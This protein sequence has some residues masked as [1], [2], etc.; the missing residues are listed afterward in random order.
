MSISETIAS[1]DVGALFTVIADSIGNVLAPQGGGGS[2]AEG[3][4]STV[5]KIVSGITAA[6][7]G[8]QELVERIIETIFNIPQ[9]QATQDAARN[10]GETL[11]NIVGGAIGGALSVIADVSRFLLGYTD[12]LGEWRDG[13]AQHIVN[14]LFPQ[15]EDG[16]EAPA[17][18]VER[19]GAWLQG[20]SETVLNY[21]LG[22][23][24]GVA[25]GG[26]G[27]AGAL[28]GRAEEMVAAVQA[29]A[30][31]EHSGA[32]RGSVGWHAGGY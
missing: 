10:L 15:A 32:H 4:A 30:Q 2:L 8:G 18:I 1:L 29:W 31:H 11:G 16:G 5:D 14:A 13:L 27:G 28:F 20:L 24:S 21:V 26:A 7:P 12:E 17:G 3:A 6:F 19:V 25:G 22:F 23:F 9:E